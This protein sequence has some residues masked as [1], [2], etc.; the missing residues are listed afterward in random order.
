[1]KR[2]VKKNQTLKAA[3]PEVRIEGVKELVKKKF[4]CLKVVIVKKSL[5]PCTGQGSLIGSFL[6]SKKPPKA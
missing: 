4:P 1:M 3:S 2:R 6:C 5:E